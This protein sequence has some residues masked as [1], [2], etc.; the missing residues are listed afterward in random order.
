MDESGRL[1]MELHG[2][3]SEIDPARW[4]AGAADALRTRLRAIEARLTALTQ[5]TWPEAGAALRAK[6]V[7]MGRALAALLPHEDATTANARAAWVAF[8][9]AM[10][11]SYEALQ[12][13]LHELEIHVPSLR[14]TN[15]KRTV[16]HVVSAFVAIGILF[17]VPSHWWAI[18]IAVPL[19]IFGW[20]LELLRKDRPWFNA[21][22][23]RILGP[24]AHPHEHRRVNSATW[25]CSALA[26]LALAFDP[27][28]SAI[29]LAALGVG[30]PIAA[31]VGRR[32]GR[33]KLVHGRSLEGT[34]SFA[35]VATIAGTLVAMLFAPDLAWSVALLVAASG[36]VAGALAEL[37]SLR[38]DDNFSVPMVGAGAATIVA[39]FLGVIA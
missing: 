21:R 19:A 11:P 2:A 4:H 34:L 1:V 18:G 25:Y 16:V 30:D 28:A 15:A 24:I 20:T 8:R 3:L 5:Q 39:S 35:L 36:G 23:M 26:L 14:P 38:I 27:L 33:V 7:D 31:L 29:G 17:L 32:F 10:T 13:T 22:V 37:L 12:N 9:N 6:L